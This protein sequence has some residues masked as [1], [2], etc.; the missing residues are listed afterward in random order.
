MGGDGKTHGKALTPHLALSPF[1]KSL[2]QS[3]GTLETSSGKVT[4]RA[5]CGA[6]QLLLPLPLALGARR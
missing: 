3:R 6:K 1:F 4:R 5:S 2:L